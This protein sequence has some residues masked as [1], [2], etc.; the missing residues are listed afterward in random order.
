MQNEQRYE[1]RELV[2]MVGITAS[3]KSFHVN[4]HYI[5]DHQIIS[6]NHIIEALKLE[7]IGIDEE[8]KDIIMAVSTRALMIRGL[9]IVIDEPNLLVESLFIW[10][11]LAHYHQYKTKVVLI[12]TPY[13]ICLTRLN[14]LFPGQVDKGI[15]KN[16][17][18]QFQQL[19]ELKSVLSMEHQQIVDEVE[20]IS[21]DGGQK[22]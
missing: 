9:P 8:L 12:D 1:R 13:D 14:N 7:S 17:E 11:R 16:L 10:K 4:K 2:I 21:Y 15:E 5:K 6:E 22:E 19:Q 3:G 20:Y 18:K